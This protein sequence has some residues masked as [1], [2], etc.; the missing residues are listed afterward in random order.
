MEKST[1]FVRG[2][3]YT[4]Y[5]EEVNDVLNGSGNV[6][7]IA[8]MAR[9]M[10]ANDFA[11]GLIPSDTGFGF[12][13]QDLVGNTY[14]YDFVW[15]R[16]GFASVN[17]S[18]GGAPFMMSNP[19]VAVF[20]NGPFGSLKTAL[21]HVTFDGGAPLAQLWID[22]TLV[23]EESGVGSNFVPAPAGVTTIVGSAVRRSAGGTILA[24]GDL[25]IAG[26]GI[27]NRI[28]TPAEITD[29]YDA[30]VERQEFANTGVFE[31]LW[32]A[33]SGARDVD[34]ATTAWLDEISQAPVARAG[35]GPRVL[36]SMAAPPRFE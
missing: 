13:N 12:D 35:A 31:A 17:W 27:V 25:H 2:Y 16:N 15:S 36:E 4:D 30:C 1:T 29:H 33:R 14:G 10:P 24:E 28:L 11:S 34:A 6:V 19:S 26:F 20:N 5:W 21:V 23:A 7:T 22:G 8:M 9:G 32:N 18:S 3:T